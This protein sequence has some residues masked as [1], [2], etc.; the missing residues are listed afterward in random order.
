MKRMKFLYI[1]GM[2]AASFLFSVSLTTAADM[3]MMEH[4]TGMFSGAKVNGGTATI[5]H[6]DG[7]NILTASDDF[8]P[9]TTPDPHWQV[10]DS[11][12]NVYQLQKLN[13]KGDK[14]NKSIVIPTYVP[15]VAKV[16]VWCAFA[17]TLLGEASFKEPVMLNMMK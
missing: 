6:K 2:V 3:M 8:V 9:P 5:S 14:Y 17:E 7:K 1:L 11:K 4:T 12:G 10:V 16:Q 15:D 13:I